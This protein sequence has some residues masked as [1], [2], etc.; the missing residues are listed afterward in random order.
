MG[1][2]VAQ[3]ATSVVYRATRA[4]RTYAIKVMKPQSKGADVARQR[5]AREA[6]LVARLRH[7]SLV[8]VVEQGDVDGQSYLVM[9]LVAGRSLGQSL[10]GGTL[11]SERWLTVARALAGALTEVHRHGMVHR[12]VKPDNV[13][14]TDDDQ[15]WLIDFGFAGEAERDAGDAVVGTLLYSPP[16]QSGLL[17][18]PVDARSD[19]YALGGTLFHC[20]AGRPPFEASDAGELVHMHAAVAPPDLGAIA[21]HLPATASRIVAKLLAKDPDDRYQSARALLQ[22]L[23]DIDR[24]ADEPLGAGDAAEPRV[25]IPFIGRTQQ[26]SILE[27]L[28][29]D[30][31]NGRGGVAVAEGPAGSGKSRLVRE[32]LER[33]KDDCR[34]VISGK[35][36][37]DEGVPFAVLREAVDAML[38]GDVEDTVIDAVRTAAG[39]FGAQLSRLSGALAKTLGGG[40]DSARREAAEIERFDAMVAAFFQGLSKQLGPIA[41]HIDDVQWADEGTL[42]VMRQLEIKLGELPLLVLATSRNAPENREGL[43]EFVDAMQVPSDCRLPLTPLSDPQ[44]RELMQG[45]LGARPLDEASVKRLIALAEGNP[46]AMGEY[47][48]ALFESGHLRP[49]LDGW[50]ADS[51]GLGEVALSEDVSDLI[52]KRMDGLMEGTAEVIQTAALVGSTFSEELLARLFDDGD[53]VHNA[54]ADAVRVSLVHAAGPGALSFVP[55]RV[56]EAALARIATDRAKDVHDAIATAL[57]RE[58]D[59]SAAASFALATHVNQGHPEKNPARTFSANLSAGQLA[60]Q[61]YS[62]REALEWLQR[63]HALHEAADASAEHTRALNEALGL[64]CT[65]TG[66]QEEAVGHLE[67]ALELAETDFGR[68]R[69]H[70]L[71]AQSYTAA[72]R[73][74]PHCWDQLVLAMERLGEKL[75]TSKVVQVITMA[76]FWFVSVVLGV[77][78]TGYGSATGED[79]AKRELLSQIHA[80]GSYLAIWEADSFLFLH[81]VMRELRN[82]HAL[83]TCAESSMAHGLYSAVLGLL[84]LRWAADR[85]GQRAMAIAEQVG[86]PAL[87]AVVKAYYA[88]GLEWSGDLAT[89]DRMTTEVWPTITRFAS[90]YYSSFFVGAYLVKLGMIGRQDDVLEL[91]PD[92]LDVVDR[93]NQVTAMAQVRLFIYAALLAK[94]RTIEAEEIK[95]E[96]FRYRAVFPD[97]GYIRFGCTI[98][99]LFTAADSGVVSD[100]VEARV[101]DFYAINSLDYYASWSLGLIGMHYLA[102]LRIATGDADRKRYRRKIAKAV[103]RMRIRVLAPI[104]EVDL[105]L[106]RSA[107]ASDAGR[108]RRARRFMRKASMAAERCQAPIGHIHLAV[109]RARL[110][111]LTGQASIAADEAR[112]AATLA[113]SRGFTYRAHEIRKEFGLV[114]AIPSMTVTQSTHAYAGQFATNQQLHALLEVSMASASSLDPD[115]QADAAL[116]ALVRLLGAERGFIF[117]EDDDG[118]LSCSAGRDASGGRLDDVTTYSRTVIERV[119]AVGTPLVLT[120]SEDGEVIGSESVAQHDLRSIMAAPLHFR[121]QLLGV[122]YLDNRLARGVFAKKQVGVLLAIANHIAISFETARNARREAERRA[123]EKDLELTSAVQSLLMPQQDSAVIGGVRLA[124]HYHPASHCGGDWWWYE[125]LD[126]GSV[127][128]L[129]GDVTGHGAAPAM[130]TAAIAGAYHA[131]RGRPDVHASLVHIHDTIHTLAGRLYSATM[132]AVRIDASSG[133]V[134]LVSAGAPPVLILRAGGKLD[135]LAAAGTPLGG[136]TPELG[137]A[138]ASITAGDRV[139]VCSDG[140]FELR[141][142]TRRE[143]GHRRVGRML[144]ATRELDC[145]SATAQLASALDDARGGLPYDD[146]VTFMVADVE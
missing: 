142:P 112:A 104:A 44:M 125:A 96:Y 105:W 99:E 139:L 91:A 67:R 114:T 93:S 106:L 49:T 97:M 109:E 111:A 60:L 95:Q 140:A 55:D 37:P 66:Q 5:F 61:I 69:L 25:E 58:T 63:A 48:L 119:A 3:G 6:A 14:V 40:T 136:A 82:V 62:N 23:D 36:R 45:H 33:M 141:T 78:R 11:S 68:A 135:S 72:G 21:E 79:R 65:R 143:L 16:E 4:E 130:V 50:C 124:G 121:D 100:E 2:V 108:F 118:K 53:R 137:R 51:A 52:V 32:A 46:F 98:F 31:I 22:D 81:L 54:L 24:L 57:E 101:D 87:A 64:V 12:D 70:L 85:Y 1:P 76:W 13:M 15:V 56:R 38:R 39:D 7:P 19:L 89:S 123:M 90:A 47:V 30:A 20:A 144:A 126:D 110:T 41:L 134:E 73:N 80:A 132:A 92:V 128:L 34:L 129:L 75:P 59:P 94:G 88:I 8:E 113:E 74:Y 42:R 117:L 131:I 77:T 103:R 17:S 10:A 83:G 35:C 107:L 146:D 86:D 115:D 43:E 27:R 133:T 120:G 102:R 28:W 145:V 84:R 71:L 9:P 29:D 138:S 18:R 116:E 127:L 122:V 26:L